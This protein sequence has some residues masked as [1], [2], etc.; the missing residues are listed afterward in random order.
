[1]IFDF[2]SLILHTRL[3]IISNTDHATSSLSPS[4]PPR[5]LFIVA[6]EISES[7]VGTIRSTQHTSMRSLPITSVDQYAGAIHRR[8]VFN[9]C[10]LLCAVLTRVDLIRPRRDH[11]R[12]CDVWCVVCDVWCVVWCGVV[13]DVWCGV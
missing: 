8:R 13:C 6:A 11:F 7:N 3:M 2:W 4:V 1:M 9:M 10:C 12:L 5:G